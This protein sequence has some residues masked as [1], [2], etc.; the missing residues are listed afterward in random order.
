VA[1]VVAWSA[2]MTWLV[3]HKVLPP[4]MIGEPP[5]YVAVVNTE[6][7]QPPVGW[8]LSWNGGRLG[9]AVSTIKRQENLTTEIRSHIHFDQL[10][11]EQ[12]APG[13]L[14]PFMSAGFPRG[15]RAA[16]E[17]ESTMTIDPLGR[18]ADFDSALR[19]RPWQSLVRVRGLIDGNK[20]KLFVHMADFSAEP[21]IPLPAGARLTDSLAP[22][23]RLPGLWLGQ[24]WSV[25]SYSPINFLCDPIGFVEGRNPLEVLQARV[26]R[27]VPIEWQQRREHVW[28]VVYCK[29]PQTESWSGAGEQICNR[30]WV[31]RDGTILRQ[32]VMLGRS[33]LT[34]SR[35]PDDRATSLLE[36][37]DR[38]KT[39]GQPAGRP[40]PNRAR[41]EPSHD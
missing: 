6:G 14:Q 37:A 28:M 10:P 34:F 38:L 25:S 26:E 31:R 15:A 5:G 18:L 1:V 36:S 12:W 30:L 39:P 41:T 2:S 27:L 32:Q 21:E 3:V 29:E 40:A 8:D 9:W 33:V 35:L 20:L 17:A 22:Q 19:L 11:L 13:W 4:L 23:V 16:M 24:Q 7:P